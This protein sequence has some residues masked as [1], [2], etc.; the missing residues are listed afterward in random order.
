MMAF[1]GRA[2]AGA[3][4]SSQ[5]FL[6]LRVSVSAVLGGLRAGALEEAVERWE[7]G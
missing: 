6:S 3:I 2:L 4:A 7:S 1:M 5:D